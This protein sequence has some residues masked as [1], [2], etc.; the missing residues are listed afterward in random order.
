MI[1]FLKSFMATIFMIGLFIVLYILEEAGVR[2]GLLEL[3]LEH[4]WLVCLVF[5]GASF[6]SLG[7]GGETEQDD[8]WAIQQATLMTIALI[9]LAI[10]YKL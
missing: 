8:Q 6:Y 5:W 4:F 2:L 7:R 3:A 1:E 10:F 9:L